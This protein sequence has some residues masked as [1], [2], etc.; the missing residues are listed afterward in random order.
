MNNTY[1]LNKFEENI[2]LIFNRESNNSAKK[3]KLFSAYI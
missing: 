2:K 1:S 3:Y